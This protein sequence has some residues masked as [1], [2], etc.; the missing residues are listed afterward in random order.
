VLRFC[1][2]HLSFAIC[3]EI[4]SDADKIVQ[5]GVS[6]LVEQDCRECAQWVYHEPGLNRLMEIIAFDESNGPF[7]RNAEETEYKVESLEDGN[8]LHGAI[9]VLCEEIPESLRPEIS[10]QCC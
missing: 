9:E 8:W 4:Y 3:P 5:R 7:I 2:A 6:A 1:Q 10:F